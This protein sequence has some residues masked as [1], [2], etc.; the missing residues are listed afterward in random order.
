MLP[1]LA[2][3]ADLGARLPGG[4]SEADEPRAQAALE[5][6]SSKIRS[7]AGVTWTTDDELDDDVPDIIVTICCSA[8]RRSFVNPDGVTGENAGSYGFTQA[9]ASPDVYLTK[10]EQGA[11]RKAAGKS[12]M[13]SQPMTRGGPDVTT[14]VDVTGT[15]E[16]LP[17][18]MPTS[19]S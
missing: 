15:D 9:N 6:A 7:V 3:V 14:W 10:A 11:V 8:A 19:P 5:D 4:I 12:G 17:V 16:P 13:W 1:P 18:D 2:A